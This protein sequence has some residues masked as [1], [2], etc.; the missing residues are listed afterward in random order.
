MTDRVLVTGSSGFIG[1]ALTPAL[2]NAGYDVFALERYVSN[3]YNVPS[4][5][6]VKTVF[7]DLTDYLAVDSLLRQIRPEIVIHLA[8]LSAVA[9]SYSRW[10]EFLEVNFNGTVNLAESALRH[11]SNLKQFVYAGTSECY[12]NQQKFPINETAKYAPNSPYSVS[13]VASINYLE[14]MRDS[15]SFPVTILLP[16]NTYGRQSCQH[17]VTERIIWQMLNG[18]AVRLG[19]PEPIRDLLYIDDH[20]AAYLSTL[21][22]P[23]AFGERINV[24]TGKGTSIRELAEKIRKLTD[25][26]GDVVWSTI[27]KRPL[28]ITKLVG[29]NSKAKKVLDWKPRVDLDSGLEKT[30]KLLER[31]MAC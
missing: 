13:K 5:A 27:P 7:A 26:Q 8:A 24:C 10:Q 18:R 11:D 23:Q 29:D 22:V 28:D 3:R 6:K 20:V 2:T 16:F 4:N 15:Y 30:V 9:S 12:G 1:S 25:F 19:D 14:Y 21:N 17:F 31:N